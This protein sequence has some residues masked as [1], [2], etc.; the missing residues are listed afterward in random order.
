MSPALPDPQ[1]RAEF[2][3]AVVMLAVALDGPAKHANLELLETICAAGLGCT[4]A[5][6][7][8]RQLGEQDSAG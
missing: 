3:D 4:V 5:D 1:A 8:A 6:L 7:L 2:E